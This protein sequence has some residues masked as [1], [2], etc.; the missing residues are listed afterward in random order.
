VA[1]S[2]KSQ[3]TGLTCHLLEPLWRGL[4]GCKQNAVNN[5]FEAAFHLR[6]NGLSVNAWH[7]NACSDNFVYVKL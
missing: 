1:A 7:K 5:I 2:V 3:N 6:L 4:L